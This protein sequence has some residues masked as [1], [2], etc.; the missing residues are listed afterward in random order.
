[1]YSALD[2]CTVLDYDVVVRPLSVD[3]ATLGTVIADALIQH[4]VMRAT[5][6]QLDA[7]RTA[8]P[9]ILAA[10]YGD[11]TAFF[12]RGHMLRTT[13]GQPRESKITL[14]ATISRD[15]SGGLEVLSAGI[16]ADE[17]GAAIWNLWER[18]VAARHLH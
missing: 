4:N 10:A 17:L 14:G 6:A 5:R 13:R 16:S 8:R 2:R 18:V 7:E 9:P 11:S 15:W 1:M 3:T 12:A